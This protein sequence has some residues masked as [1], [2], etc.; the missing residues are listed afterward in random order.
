MNKTFKFT[1]I[2]SSRFD[3]LPII[4]QNHKKITLN[5]DL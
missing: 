5:Y 4:D 1:K 3:R 2:K